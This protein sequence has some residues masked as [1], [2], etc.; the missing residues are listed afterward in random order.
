[1]TYLR[2]YLDMCKESPQSG[3]DVAMKR[4]RSLPAAG[5]EL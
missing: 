3:L 4:K 2:N 1:M 5:I